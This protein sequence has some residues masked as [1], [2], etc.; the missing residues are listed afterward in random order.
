[1]VP[2][3][4]NIHTRNMVASQ[5]PINMPMLPRFSPMLPPRYHALNASILI[6]TQIPS[7]TPG[8]STPF[9][10]HLV[11]GFIPKLPRPPFRGSLPSPM[12]GTNPSGTTQYFTPDY[13]IP[14]GGQFHPGAK[15]NPLLEV[16]SQLGCNL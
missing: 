1:M 16:K 12:V 7:K 9:G 5:A 11:L 8:I 14:I 13:H 10:H 6:P 4:T 15:Y 3:T 2:D